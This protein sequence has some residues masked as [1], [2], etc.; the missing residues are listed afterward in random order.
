VARTV[1]I[2]LL[3]AGLSTWASAQADHK[4]LAPD[5]ARLL[6]SNHDLLKALLIDALAVSDA[7]D[8]TL[9]R[10]D[11]SR[12][13]AK[14]LSRALETA[15]R[16]D[17]PDANRVAELSDHLGEVLTDGLHAALTQ[18]RSE[19]REGSPGFD[20]FKE[21]DEQATADAQASAGLIPTTGKFADRDAVRKARER[22]ADA[23]GKFQK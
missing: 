4:L 7:G 22:L 2:L 5:Q 13:A 9:D 12:R 19:F 3:A 23:A 8:S 20:R 10:I 21:L 1:L 16:D 17:S 18:A 6:A 14:T 11:A 15:C